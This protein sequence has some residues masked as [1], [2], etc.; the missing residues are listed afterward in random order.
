MKG[1][2]TGGRVKGVPNRA[3]REIKSLAQ[4]YGPAVIKHLYKLSKEAE[5]EAAQ[6]AAGKELLDRAYGKS[7]QAV[8]HSGAIG[9]YDLSKV[10]DGDL[11]QLEAILGTAAVT[12]GG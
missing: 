10:S 1:K 11:K 4:S 9:S 12:G 2:K 6:V 7:P 3:T 8:Q 5:S